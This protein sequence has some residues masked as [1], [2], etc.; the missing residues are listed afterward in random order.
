V[1]LDT[2]IIFND[3]LNR[4]KAML[5]GAVKCDH[6]GE[7][8]TVRWTGTTLGFSDIPHAGPML[9]EAVIDGKQ[10]VSM[11]RKQTA[12]RKYARFWYLPEQSPGAHEV[13]LTIK[14]LPE[15]ASFYA[16]QILIIGTPLN[17]REL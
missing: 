1:N 8:I 12:E 14:Q 17:K 11:E 15:G 9:V 4:T 3:D 7:T 13:C 5:R 2:D 16:G 10:R 6:P